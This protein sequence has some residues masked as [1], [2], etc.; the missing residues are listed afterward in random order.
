MVATYF[1]HS[2]KKMFVFV[3]NTVINIIFIELLEK[4]GNTGNHWQPFNEKLIKSL[5]YKVDSLITYW[6]PTSN[7]TQHTTTG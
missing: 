3:I 4:T 1:E 5:F 7:R 2:K 6:Q